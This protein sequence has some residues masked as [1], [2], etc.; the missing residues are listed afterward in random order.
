[1]NQKI[2]PRSSWKRK[3][4]QI[5]FEADTPAGR[6]FD[7]GLLI[8]IVFSVALVML[9]SI[10][11]FRRPPTGAY[12]NAAEWFFTILFTIE[13]A[14]RLICVRKPHEYAFSFFGIVDL[15]AIVPTYLAGAIILLAPEG[16]LA[17][18]SLV[19]IRALRL[20]RIFR[21]LKLA[22]FLS[23]ARAMRLALWRS[24]A[25]V[26]VFL[27]TVLIVVVIMGAA[28]YLIEG[29][30]H[31]FDSIPESMYWAIVTMTTVGYGD[32]APVTAGG[33]LI[34]AFLMLMGYGIIAVPTGI[35]SA[36]L[37]RADRP[38]KVS[39]HSCP[40]CSKE[41]HDIDA[42]HCKFCGVR[43]EESPASS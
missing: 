19:V 28:L 4:H 9:E 26:V 20:L 36:E 40:S 27:T 11:S 29:P 24:R 5:I 13:Y 15:A 1:M 14:L 41:G 25:K 2:D 37:V 31:G 33:R 6:A 7:I 35:V 32:I 10:E 8:A 39:T 38:K 17:L 3:T 43:L 30:D 22:R 21:I 34:A 16:H 12:L 23:E 42:V 18:E